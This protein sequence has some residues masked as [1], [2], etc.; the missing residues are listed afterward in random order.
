MSGIATGFTRNVRFGRII[1]TDW[2]IIPIRGG[3]LDML[4]NR[5]YI[6]HETGFAGFD[7]WVQY[8]IPVKGFKQ[9]SGQLPNGFEWGNRCE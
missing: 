7:L 1:G 6:R 9:E 3:A 2:S 5:F 4:E 8:W